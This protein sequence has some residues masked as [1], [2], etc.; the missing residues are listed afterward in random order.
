MDSTLS[1]EDR[2]DDLLARLTLEEKVAQMQ[3]DA[4]AIQRL[5]IGGYHWWN[6]ALHGV[7]RNGTAT[8]FPQAIGMAASWNPELHHQMAKVIA[9]EGRAKHA[10]AIRFGGNSRQYAGLDFW[11]PNINIFRDPRWGRGQE[12]YGEDP[13]LTS[14]LGIAFVKGLQ[15]EDTYYFQTIATPKH[16]AVH[17][18]PEMERHRF[19]ATPSET[20]L[21][22]TYLPAFEATVREGKAYSVMAA[23]NSVGGLPATASPRLLTDILRREWG[24][25]GYVTSD[26]DSVSDVHLNHAFAESAEAAAAKSVKAG[27]DLNG[28][29]T[30]RALTEAVRQGL[31]TEADIDKALRRLFTARFRLGE[32][33]PADGN[34]YAAIPPSAND[35]EAHDAIAHRMA[36]ESMVLLKNASS[37]LPWKK[38]LRSIAVIGPTSDSTAALYGNY[39]GI[40]SRPITILQGIRNTLPVTTQVIY[41]DGCPLVTENIGLSEPVPAACFYADAARTKKGLTA[42]YFRSVFSTDRPIRT[43]ID[44]SVDLSFPDQS[45][46][47][48]IAYADGL[49]ARW[50]GVLVPP[51]TGDYQIGFNGKD[52]FR[53]TV[54]GKVVVDEWYGGNRRN[55]GSPIRLEKDKAYA[56]LAEYAHPAAPGGAASQPATGN[57]RDTAYV[58]MRWT[59]PTPDGLPAAASGLPLYKDAVDAAKAADAVVMVL[60][61]TADLEKEEGA[62]H[63]AGFWG[64]DR[65]SL[66]LPLVQERMLQQVT[67]AAAGKPVVLVL[68]SGSALAVNW[69]NDN[70]PA[71]L[72][73]WYP[74]QHGDAVADVIFGDY[75]PAGRLPVTFY[76]SVNDLPPFESY[77][78]EG[79]TYRY[80]SKPVLYPFGHGLSYT[81]FEYS[82]VKVPPA[83]LATTDDIT[84]TATVKNTGSR[85]GSE[86]V[87]CYLNRPLPAPPAGAREETTP[88]W[89][90]YDFL[91]SQPRKT[92]IGF[93]RV[94]LEAGE[95]KNVSFTITPHQLARVDAKGKRVLVTETVQVQVGGS[96]AS[97]AIMPLAITA[98]AAT[99]EYRFAAPRVL[100]GE[101]Q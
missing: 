101:G 83:H 98:A 12:T 9:D 35:I 89:A 27:C 60:G 48:S 93:L 99:P 91:A 39:N 16:F 84:V 19:N 43:R 96:S 13:Y 56:I 6:E 45:S 97:G 18:G 53:L 73:A 36:R 7:G 85:A 47:D 30:Y 34:P 86:V 94:P 76:K 92:L 90:A 65:T 67:A 44:D 66:D 51:A 72:Q 31:L 40:A 58:Q 29:T 32:F 17:S 100:Q 2:L 10:D 37:T 88:E 54:D 46:R 22:T 59:R 4:P 52:S 81:T 26:V 11:S 70:V 33:D 95:Q 14:R 1:L 21:F 38:D 50:T 8:V 42:T 80:L 3:M 24:F 71:I 5:G 57:Q 23:Y 68:T 74:G 75:N 49:Y 64:G 62:I 20:D 28:G 78:M 87:Q 63:N 82:N 69:A 79:R 61:I 55:T 41:T 15:G 25:Q 77:A